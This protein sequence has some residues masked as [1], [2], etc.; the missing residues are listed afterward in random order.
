MLEP[1]LPRPASA[2]TSPAAA[3]SPHP[4]VIFIMGS[5]HSGS[6]ILSVTLG[7]CTGCFYAGELL[8]FLSQAGTP[9]LGGVARSRFWGVVRDAVP[10]AEDLFGYDSLQLIERS[11]SLL[12]VGNWSARRRL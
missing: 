1:A 11:M 6:T 12:R 10:D 5:G 7:N 3:A 9:T 2:K 4:K 8:N